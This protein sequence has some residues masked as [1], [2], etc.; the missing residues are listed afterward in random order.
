MTKYD[1]R[2]EKAFAAAGL[3]TDAQADAA[4]FAVELEDAIVGFV[5]GL[6]GPRQNPV[7]YKQI[8]AHVRRWP[9]FENVTDDQI[10]D[11]EIAGIAMDRIR[12][13]AMTLG[14]HRRWNGRYG[15]EVT[16]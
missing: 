14:S 10:N 11:A 12:C 7:T 9:M 2:I 16:S 15:Y 6:R 5:R 3:P 4:L 1:P 8:V 13:V